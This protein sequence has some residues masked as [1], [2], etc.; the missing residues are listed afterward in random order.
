MYVFPSASED[1]GLNINGSS[2]GVSLSH[3]ALL[4]FTTDN[5][6]GFS[7]TDL[8]AMIK[9]LQNY[10]MNMETVL[11]N[12]ERYNY[13]EPQ[14]V[15]ESVFWHWLF[16]KGANNESESLQNLTDTDNDLFRENN[17]NSNNENRI[18]QCFGE[19]DS[20]NSLSTDFGMFNE[21]YVNI[22][23][24]YGN[25]PVFFRN[26]NN[27]VNIKPGTQYSAVNVTGNFIEG[28]SELVDGTGY[29][30]DINAVYDGSKSYTT[31][32]CLEIVKDLKTIEYA[33]NKVAV[34]SGTSMVVN[35]YD[36]V[37]IDKNGQYND[38]YKMTY[39]STNGFNF[40]AI[41]LYYSIY[42][43]NDVQKAPVATNLFGIVFLDGVSNNESFIID[44]FNKRKSYTDSGNTNNSFFGNS[45]SFR[46]NIKT[47]S[48]YDN[49]DARIDDNTTTTSAYSQDFND[50]LANL[51]R[52]IDVMNTNVHSTMAI[53]DKYFE[54][55]QYYAETK[56][57][58]EDL[59]KEYEVYCDEQL[60]NAVRE[61]EDKLDTRFKTLEEELK[62]QLGL[63][64]NDGTTTSDGTLLG[65]SRYNTV[66]YKQSVKP[67][68]T[69]AEDDD[70][71][72]GAPQEPDETVLKLD[73]LMKKVDVLQ[74][75]V[76]ELS[77][78]KEE[79]VDSSTQAVSE[80][81]EQFEE[82]V[83]YLPFGMYLCKGILLPRAKKP[84][85]PGYYLKQNTSEQIQTIVYFN[86]TEY[87][88]TDKCRSGKMYSVDGSIYVF[89]GE[90]CKLLGL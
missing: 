41:L 77:V 23:T 40:N 9:S 34:K 67:V 68:I 4:N 89:N 38:S 2:N 14:T 86:G 25:G 45:F 21:V 59:K 64:E 44:P 71:L 90:T 60:T 65:A 88:E 47:M 37:N 55:R 81:S 63:L 61:L 26:N 8:N 36:D 54:I 57:K 46:V 15:S 72:M 69:Q 53:Q 70:Y 22:P 29:L 31:P 84:E 75:M 73:E 24:S 18:V 17:Y 49:T 3:Y 33:V 39:A 87:T 12:Q 51:N 11:I 43:L 62:R 58:F 16:N 80:K 27:N 10:A 19:I 32:R 83:E 20:A 13:Q 66:R 56:T 76:D 1:I 78:E 35:S 74:T 48:V 50:V 79:V 42:D 7:R 82:T 30:R 5:M 85:T 28:R 6:P 52:A